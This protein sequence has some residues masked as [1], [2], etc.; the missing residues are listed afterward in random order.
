MKFKALQT[1]E[2]VEKAPNKDLDSDAQ[3]QLLKGEDE[4]HVDIIVST[5]SVEDPESQDVSTLFFQY[6]GLYLRM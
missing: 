2:E 3:T 5:K 1:A 4:E 6:H